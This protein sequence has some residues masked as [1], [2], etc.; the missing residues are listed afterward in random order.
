MNG[1]NFRYGEYMNEPCFSLSLVYE[2][3]GVRG[4]QPHARTQ[5]HGKCV[6]SRLGENDA[7]VKIGLVP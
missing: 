6:Q 7:C 4:L 5:N 3:G 2:W 1:V